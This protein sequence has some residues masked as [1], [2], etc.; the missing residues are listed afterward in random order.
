MDGWNTCLLS[1]WP[2]FRRYVKLPEGK[3][4]LNISHGNNFNIEKQPN[5]SEEAKPTI[6]E[7]SPLGIVP[8]TR[9][10]YTWKEI[11]LTS[12]FQVSIQAILWTTLP[13]TNSL[14]PESGFCW[15]TI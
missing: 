1:G 9:V 14:P 15:K 7:N 8:T 5:F 11:S 12:N 13:E 3:V 4:S 2:I 10:R 6:F